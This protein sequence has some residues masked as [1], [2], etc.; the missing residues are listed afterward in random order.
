[1]S[2]CGFSQMNSSYQVKQRTEEARQ[3][4][5]DGKY[6]MAYTAF[7]EIL[8]SGKVIPSNLSYYFAE[9]LYHI[10][11]YQNSKNFIEK[12]IK[13]TGKGGDYFNEAT[14][15]STLLKSE[16]DKIT[17]CSYCDLTGYRLMPCTQCHGA[18]STIESCHICNQTGINSC[19][20]CLG[21]GVIIELDVLGNKTYKTCDKCNGEGFHTCETCQGSKSIT[22]NC[23]VC[24]GSG[25]EKSKKLCDHTDHPELDAN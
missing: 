9:T 4:M 12:Y 10:G 17:E 7:R 21:E 20:K 18:K 3:L 23:P 22:L 14:E 11:Q 24:L 13:I 1:M 2:T 5:Q 15:L 16:F 19:K 6:D 25:L 8:S